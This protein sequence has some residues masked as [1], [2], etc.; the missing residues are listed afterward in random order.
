V[1]HGPEYFGRDCTAQHVHITQVVTIPLAVNVQTPPAEEASYFVAS[2]NL[3]FSI[4]M[5]DI[6]IILEQLIRPQTL[7]F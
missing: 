3:P 2:K 5:K 1:R 7:H 4:P 6:Q